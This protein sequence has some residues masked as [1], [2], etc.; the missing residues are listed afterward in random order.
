[1]GWVTTPEGLLSPA[2][3]AMGSNYKPQ[4]TR[5]HLQNSLCLFPWETPSAASPEALAPS[6]YVP[7][8]GL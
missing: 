1:M 7:L 8:L 3:V 6:T 2:H 5:A 4:L